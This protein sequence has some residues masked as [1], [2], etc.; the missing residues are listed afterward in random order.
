MNFYRRPADAL[1]ILGALLAILGGYLTH[2]VMTDTAPPAR[3]WQRFVEACPSGLAP[4]AS[5]LWLAWTVGRVAVATIPLVTAC[6][7]RS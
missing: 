1:F 4:L 3:L 6:F 2:L 7:A 5:P